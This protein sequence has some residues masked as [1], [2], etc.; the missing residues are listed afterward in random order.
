MSN[1]AVIYKSHYGFT[2]TYASWIAEELSA[3]LMEA[4]KVKAADLQRYHTII[5]G[6]GLYAGGVSGVSLITQNFESLQNKS[7]YLFTVGAA[8]V[9]D[10]ENIASIKG[11][12]ARVLTPSMLEKIKVYHFRGG[13]SYSKMGFMHKAMMGMMHKMLLKKPESELRSEDK[14]MLETYGQDVSFVDKNLI[15]PL[16]QDVVQSAR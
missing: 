6:G 3:D 5:Y 8:D 2:K 7:L 4:D 1:I 9:S 15:A 10:E 13:L 16:I 12:L 11:S 14:A